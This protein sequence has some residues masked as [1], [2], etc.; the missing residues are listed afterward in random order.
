MCIYD[1]SG[2]ELSGFSLLQMTISAIV[3]SIC[4]LQNLY[5]DMNGHCQ[6]LFTQMGLFS[7]LEMFYFIA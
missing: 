6:H 7:V 5:F 1:F 3:N 4:I 2:R